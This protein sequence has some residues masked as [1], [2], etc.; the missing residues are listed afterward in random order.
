MLPP[1]YWTVGLVSFHDVILCQIQLW[2]NTLSG[3]M[4]PGLFSF[5]EKAAIVQKRD[6]YSHI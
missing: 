5:E 6:E 1:P 2:P 4:F 3:K